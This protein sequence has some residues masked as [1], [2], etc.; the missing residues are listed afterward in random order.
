MEPVEPELRR[1]ETWLR[2]G[3]PSKENLLMGEWVFRASL[4]PAEVEGFSAEVREGGAVWWVWGVR[5]TQV[6]K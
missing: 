3:Y 2:L 5:V 4:E 6:G 1:L